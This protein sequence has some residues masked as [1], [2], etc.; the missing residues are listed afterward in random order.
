MGSLALLRLPQ[1]LDLPKTGL[2]ADCCAACDKGQQTATQAPPAPVFNSAQP[3]VTTSRTDRPQPARLLPHGSVRWACGLADLHDTKEAAKDRTQ[4]SLSH[5]LRTDE[6]V[7][8]RLC[9]ASHQRRALW[10]L[11]LRRRGACVT[12]GALRVRNAPPAQAPSRPPSHPSTSTP[13]ATTGSFEPRQGTARIP[14]CAPA[15]ALPSASPALK[16]PSSDSPLPCFF[17]RP[18]SF[19]FCQE[20][21]QHSAQARGNLKRIERGSGGDLEGIWRESAGSERASPVG[22]SCEW[23]RSMDAAPFPHGS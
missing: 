7:R 6:H 9:E 16:L 3:N 14:I 10:P 19:R 13:P 4:G 22:S 23:L 17:F 15:A 8:S 21:V 18:P 5:S 1:K 11:L 12:R 20:C 2:P